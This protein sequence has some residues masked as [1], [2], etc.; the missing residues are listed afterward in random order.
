MGESTDN[1]I[2]SGFPAEFRPQFRTGRAASASPEG[3]Q[4]GRAAGIAPPVLVMP[5]AEE[6]ADACGQRAPLQ[7][8]QR[9]E[10]GIEIA[11]RQTRGKLGFRRARVEI[12]VSGG[13]TRAAARPP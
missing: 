1:R 12:A 11:Q 5:I 9:P 6:L 7:M 13:S 3:L 8:G 10:P 2:Y 4:R